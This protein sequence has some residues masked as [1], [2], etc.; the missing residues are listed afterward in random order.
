MTLTSYFLDPDVSHLILQFND[1][2][3]NERVADVN[4]AHQLDRLISELSV[5]VD[6]ITKH[7]RDLAVDRLV[8]AGLGGCLSLGTPHAGP[9]CTMLDGVFAA[10]HV[11]R[12]LFAAFTNH[13]K[14]EIFAITGYALSETGELSGRCSSFLREADLLVYGLLKQ[15]LDGDPRIDFRGFEDD[16]LLLHAG[17]SSFLC[18]YQYELDD[19]PDAPILSSLTIAEDDLSA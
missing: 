9:G 7:G 18:R 1:L 3:I 17:A 16:G 19:R 8:V 13:F 12:E 10:V 2:R 5:Q 6:A 15:G 4:D 11:L 14:L